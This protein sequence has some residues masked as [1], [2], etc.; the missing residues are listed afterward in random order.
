MQIKNILSRL[1]GSAPVG[2]NRDAAEAGARKAIESSGLS[3]ASTSP[4]ANKLRDILAA[5]DVTSITPKAFSEML[6]KLQQSAALPEKDLQE[7][8]QIRTDMERDGI[9]PDQ[10][11]NL[12]DVY[13]KKIQAAIQDSD[14][15]EQKLG[16]AGAQ[17][18]TSSLRRRLEW[19]QKFAAIHTSPEGT[20]INALA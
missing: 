9:S 14:E 17:D 4:S 15:L 11:V 7:L 13:T 18:F 10:R 1:S 2:Q 5:Y 3:P 8:S 16:T 19:V 20:T 6:Q 12:L